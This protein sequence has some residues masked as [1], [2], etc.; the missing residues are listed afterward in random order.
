MFVAGKV[1]GLDVPG[2]LM[3]HNHINYVQSPKLFE[4]PVTVLGDLV[5]AERKRIQGVDV[6]EW[7]K[8]SVLK[9]GG[10]FEID[11]HKTFYNP[12]ITDAR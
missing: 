8:K 1:N 3:R 10:E 6:S 7:Y 9:D 4:K 11:G 12:S 5:M 2:G